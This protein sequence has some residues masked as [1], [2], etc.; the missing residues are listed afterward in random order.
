M[1]SALAM[2]TP[3][4]FVEDPA[5]LRVAGQIKAHDL[6][7]RIPLAVHAIH[8]LHVFVWG[9]R[10]STRAASTGRSAFGLTGTC[11]HEKEMHSGAEEKNV[12][13]GRR[14]SKTQKAC[15]T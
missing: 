8:L 3:T 14:Q 1:L 4:L 9:C 10:V 11:D 6:Q 5:S 7:R 12:D 2:W 13:C 15:A